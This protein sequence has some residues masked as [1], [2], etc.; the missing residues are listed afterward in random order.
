MPGVR[1]QLQLFCAIR[2]VN[3]DLDE[4]VQNSENKIDTKASNNEKQLEIADRICK[5]T[6]YVP[7]KPSSCMGAAAKSFKS[8]LYKIKLEKLNITELEVFCEEDVDFGG[9]LVIQRRQSDSVDFYRDWHNYME[10]F[11]DLTENYWISLE[12]LH[13]LTSSCE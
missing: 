7:A 3:D 2:S 1:L 9:W 6:S 11:D 4:D 10:G 13:A 12:K 5:P 8:G